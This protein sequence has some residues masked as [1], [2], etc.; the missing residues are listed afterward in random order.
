VLALRIESALILGKEENLNLFLGEKPLLLFVTDGGRT[1][2]E[3]KTLIAVERHKMMV[4][5]LPQ[6]EH[7]SCTTGDIL[8]LIQ[9]N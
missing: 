6:T 4:V 3:K 5:R 1:L 9:F 8:V 7:K 2:W